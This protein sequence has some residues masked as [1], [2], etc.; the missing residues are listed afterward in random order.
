MVDTTPWR[1]LLRTGYHANYMIVVMGAMYHGPPPSLTAG[2]GMVARLAALYASFNVLLYGGIY[3][4]NALVDLEEDRQLKPWRPL[5]TGA[6]SVP[7]ARAL[8]VALLGAGLASGAALGPN[9]ALLRL[10]GGFLATNALYSFV[11]RPL[12]GA[13]LAA[14]TVSVTAALRLALGAVGAAAA[15]GWDGGGGGGTPP[16]LSALVA[17]WAAMTS[18]HISRKKIERGER[19]V[20]AEH[21]VTSAAMLYAFARAWRD[22]GGFS[23]WYALFVLYQHVGFGL[24]PALVDDSFEKLKGFYKTKTQ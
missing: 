6:V 14:H 20:V 13:L 11:V 3:T 8:A 1:A 16:P 4:V 18:V 9:P 17:A 15:G 22:D 2:A 10:Y 5:A 21:A 24:L 7:T 19:P 12:G 23:L